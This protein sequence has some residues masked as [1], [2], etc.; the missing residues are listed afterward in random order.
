M[1]ANDDADTIGADGAAAGGA[2]T[3]ARTGTELAGGALTAVPALG[4]T[5]SGLYGDL[6]IN[7]NGT[8][9]YTLTTASIPVG[10]T[11]ETFTYQITDGD[12]DTDLAQLVVALNQ[13]A[14]YPDTTGSTGSVFEDGLADGVQHGAASET[15]TGTF[16]VDGN[17]ESYTLTLD[18][19]VGGPVTI[20]AV[21]DVV[22]TTKGTL[23]ITSISAPGRA[24]W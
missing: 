22:T 6:L 8:Y 10:T 14:L 18:G 21:N 9:T 24:A 12:G 5:I 2:V 3:G 20:T 4:V 1:S 7:P 17:N 23:T 11:S 15:T 19:D 16:A 13:N